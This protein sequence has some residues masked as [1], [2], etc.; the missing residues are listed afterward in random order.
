MLITVQEEG[1]G[2]GSSG[3]LFKKSLMWIIIKITAMITNGGGKNEKPTRVNSTL[4]HPVSQE[5]ITVKKMKCGPLANRN[6][7]RTGKESSLEIH[8]GLNRNNKLKTIKEER[9]SMAGGDITTAGGTT[10]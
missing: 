3:S 5:I 8:N 1:N 2:D 4:R 7:K 9:D 6:S 10:K